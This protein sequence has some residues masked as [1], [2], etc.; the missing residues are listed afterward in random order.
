MCVSVH[1]HN[2]HFYILKCPLL[3][4]VHS[5]LTCCGSSQHRIG[6][7]NPEVTSVSTH[8]TLM[9]TIAAYPT[10]MLPILTRILKSSHFGVVAGGVG[11]LSVSLS[12]DDQPITALAAALL[13]YSATKGA[14]DGVD[15]LR[16]AEWA[17]WAARVMTTP[18]ATKAELGKVEAQ[19][20]TSGAYIAGSAV[21]AADIAIVGAVDAAVKA[22]VVDVA[23]FPAV[24]KL[25]SEMTSQKYWVI[26]TKAMAKPVAP[27]KVEVPKANPVPFA[28]AAA[29]AASAVVGEKRPADSAVA[30]PAPAAP[31]AAG[32]GK[33][34]D[35]GAASDAITALANYT[36]SAP[37]D[38]TSKEQ[39]TTCILHE[40]NSLFSAAINAA[41][42]QAAAVG[43][44]QADVQLNAIG[45]KLVHHYQ[46]NS[47]LALYAKL[48]G[49]SEKKEK[50]PKAAA[51][52]E[53]EPAAAAP[54]PAPEPAPAP[55]A[56]PA[57]PA[58]P[59]PASPVAAA[60]AIIA[61]VTAQG[62]HFLIG[63]LEVSGPGYINI[64]LPSNYVSAR[65][66]YLLDQGV[67]AGP[68][69]GD[70]ARHA[71]V[72]YSSPNIA[73]EMH[74]GH[75]RSTII[76]DAIA[77]LLEFCGHTVTRVN[78]VG[79]WGTQF[80]MLI[81]HLKEMLA[82]GAVTD[83]QLDASIGDLTGF[84]KAAKKRFDEEP[85]FKRRAHD[86]VVALQAGDAVNLAYWKRMV[87]VSATMFNE[88]YSRLG[89]DSRLQLCGESFYNPLIPPA[90]AEIE[91]KGLTTVS[92]GALV[93]H[94]PGFEVPLMVR[95]SDG[96][97]G[98]DSTDLAAIKYRLQDLKSDWLIYV[99]DQG[100]ALH[101]DLVFRGAQMAG[102][103]DPS[104]VRV[105]HCGFGVV[106][107]EDKKKFKT[108]SGET[109]RL[110]DVLEEARTRARGIIEERVK[111]G[112]SPLSPE[113][114][115]EAGRVL[116]YGG[117][118]YFDL[119]QNRATDYV[120]SY[121]RML[122][123]DGDTAVYLEYAHARVMSILRKA[124]ESAVAIDTD[125]LA[126]NVSNMAGAFTFA[127]PT[128]L[129][130][131]AEL[132]R[133]QDVLADIQGDLMPHRLCEYLYKLSGA[134]TDFHRDCN[135]LGADT[136]VN[137]RDSRLRL[138]VATSKTMKA[139]MG[140]LGI[141]PLDRI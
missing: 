27:P 69:P 21:S 98:Y 18:E 86:E 117:V 34:A 134:F 136:P 132:M 126:T 70:R 108:R 33:A 141:T 80:G 113:D 32:K 131:A 40:L 99:V 102:W 48:R 50:K 91:S 15:E 104:A 123:P 51:A 64:Y 54:A 82:S 78:H 8:V 92:D 46:C 119:R 59:V 90:I 30:A 14:M 137:L 83:A 28:A 61:A 42:P 101:F 115:E 43:A 110:V 52:K 111:G 128:E 17:A 56:A 139:A 89:V 68:A 63:K 124:R 103:Y 4:A 55:V 6:Q 26:A 41:F 65:L 75:L 73:K 16:V 87:A 20:S 47:A 49:P 79:D 58:G 84:Y 93:L 121:D 109:V 22:K 77:R 96:G 81:A 100:Q 125:A 62:P 35:A 106:Q 130:L 29:P 45:S 9:T 114:V 24:A 72:D 95:K 94:V 127:H 118:K 12:S 36:T 120:F 88:V 39:M 1:C 133:L 2:S 13:Y 23:E 44:G 135:V 67:Q 7:G 122:S 25:H 60:Q 107:G 74:I 53:G 11:P 71:V 57:V 38:P 10:S 37:I 76:G 31:K 19:L 129:T 66:S 116:G 5:P 138:C 85:D 112:N 97:Y 140:I 105:E 3:L